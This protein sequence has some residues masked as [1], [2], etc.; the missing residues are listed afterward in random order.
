MAK[1]R[2]KRLKARKEKR[3]AEKADA[4][5]VVEKKKTAAPGQPTVASERMKRVLLFIALFVFAF[6]FVLRFFHS[7]LLL[8][9][10]SG[11]ESSASSPPMAS[12]NRLFML[13]L[14]VA[15]GIWG[16]TFFVSREFRL[17]K[18]GA[19]SGIFLL[20]FAGVAWIQVPMADYTLPALNMAIDITV[21]ALVFVFV[22]NIGVDGRA[23]RFLAALV[24][25]GCVAAAVAGLFEYAGLRENVREYVRAN[26]HMF[27]KIQIDRLM[28][29]DIYA[30]FINPNVLGTVLAMGIC[31]GAGFIAE[32]IRTRERGAWHKVRIATACTGTA[33]LLIALLL[34]RSKGG[35]VACCIG[36]LT[37]GVMLA[38]SRIKKYA[39][40]Y[41]YGLV[42]AMF[43]TLVVFAMTVLK[44]KDPTWMGESMKV[45]YGFWATSGNMIRRYGLLG[46]GGGNYGYEF[47]KFMP[48]YA[49]E[50]RHVHNSYI[51]LWAELGVAGLLFFFLF[52]ASIISRALEVPERMP[53]ER[54]RDLFGR[55]R[56]VILPLAGGAALGVLVS[57]FVTGPVTKQ[58]EHFGHA[59]LIIFLL[60]L[61][62]M[63]RLSSGTERDEN[64]SAVGK[65][66]FFFKD[67]WLTAGLLA[68]FFAFLWH[69]LVDFSFYSSGVL[70][71]FVV[72]SALLIVSVAPQKPQ[73]FFQ[74]PFSG[75]VRYGLVAFIVTVAVILG[76][77]TVRQIGA[78]IRFRKAAR[79]TGE[80]RLAL[81]A[82]SGLSGKLL[83]KSE[84]ALEKA[85]EY[86]P[87]DMRY[88]RELFLNAFEKWSAFPSITALEELRKRKDGLFEI[89]PNASRE[90]FLY[91]L[92]CREAM[93]RFSAEE[94]RGLGIDRSRV[95][96]EL[97]K[98]RNLYPSRPDRLAA[99]W[100]FY[101]ELIV[102][103]PESKRVPTWTRNALDFGNQAILNSEAAP[104]DRMRLTAEKRA[105]IEKWL[106]G[107][108]PKP[109]E[110][111]DEPSGE[112][113][114]PDGEKQTEEAAPKPAGEK[115]PEEGAPKADGD[116]QP[117]PAGR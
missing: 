108:A 15:V 52:F 79:P 56:A 112:T 27:S 75:G 74:R 66:R 22:V 18:T 10:P 24:F 51:Q 101:S 114:K 21:F 103:A 17:L 6:G 33:L 49:G 116:K 106:S 85:I 40:W 83:S 48:P 63:N 62:P 38:I 54:S 4:E 2:E 9:S 98:A 20:I 30:F 50:A 92:A 110:P 1:K 96:D 73:N 97:E 29:S 3:L 5:A 80:A 100:E 58:T 23:R 86:N 59:A 31:I 115:Q 87:C 57:R 64:Y 55:T 7:S 69:N 13:V 71:A 95:E 84:T 94:L 44:T 105:E 39:D 16:F 82:R 43:L 113:D 26:A 36:L 70:L 93:K 41:A 35:L 90:A 34:S 104:L 99:L 68:A 81:T 32:L 45:R 117:E 76:F 53:A 12:M 107:H 46:V 60:G 91:A 61:L 47:Q 28:A 65:Y 89:H 78:D 37:F 72:V 109:K 111:A 8:D 19:L 88:H 42:L 77:F 102:E 14:F 11:F 25:S 67:S